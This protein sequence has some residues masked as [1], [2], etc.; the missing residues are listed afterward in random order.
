MSSYKA[1]NV[2]KLDAGGSG[3]NYVPDKYIKSVEKVW[4]DTYALTATAL[5]TADTIDI[6]SIAP[7]HRITSVEVYLPATIAPTT[8]TINV[9]VTGDEDKFIDDAPVTWLAP[10][11][12]GLAVARMNNT[13]GMLY[14]TTGTTNTVIKLKIG[15]VALTAPTTGTI[16]TIVRYL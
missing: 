4:A 3:D 14:L 11:A 2:T 13:D 10:T 15:V 6:A 16:N 12:I 1:Q 7:G 8:S 5:S 9:G